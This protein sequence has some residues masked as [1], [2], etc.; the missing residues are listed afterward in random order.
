MSDIYLSR[1]NAGHWVEGEIIGGN[2]VQGTLYVNGGHPSFGPRVWPREAFMQ[3]FLKAPEIGGLWETRIDRPLG[4]RFMVTGIEAGKIVGRLGDTE[5]AFD[6]P[7]FFATFQQARRQEARRQEAP[8]TTPTYP[9]KVVTSSGRKHLLEVPLTEE[10]V[11]VI[12]RGVM[13]AREANGAISFESTT[14]KVTVFARRIE[15]VELVR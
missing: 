15:S 14:G 7:D 1:R 2:T 3:A 13:R 11:D 4:P 5:A 12:L 10:Q 6:G 8:E 9:V